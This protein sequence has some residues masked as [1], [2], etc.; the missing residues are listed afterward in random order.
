MLLRDGERLE[1]LLMRRALRDGDRWSG[2]VSLP[3][4]AEDARDRDLVDTAVRETREEVGVELARSARLIG[5]LP[6]AWALTRGVPRP[7]TV[8]PVVF[9]VAGPIEIAL[10]AE[11]TH[12]FWFPLG[13]AATGA[14]DGTHPY[15]LGPLR[16]SLPCWRYQGEE[17]WGLTFEM[18]RRLIA[19]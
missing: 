2:H 15:R 13:A 19:L 14:L 8:T 1:V 7:M 12:A 3:G 17:V 18:L 9:A 4:G 16:R 6:P 11:A 5:Q 10:G